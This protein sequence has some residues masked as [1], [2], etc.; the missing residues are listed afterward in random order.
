MNKVIRLNSFYEA[1]S[2]EIDVFD[3]YRIKDKNPVAKFTNGPVKIGIETKEPPIGISSEY[4]TKPMIGIT[5][6][7]NSGWRGKIKEI[8]EL[9]LYIPDSMELDTDSCD[10]SGT[11]EISDKSEY[12]GYSA[13]KLQN[14]V[15]KRKEL[16]DI[17]EP[18]SFKCRLDIRTD[19][20]SDVLGDAPFA[21]KY[22]R[23]SA[24]YIFETEKSA[25]VTVAL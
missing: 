15:K 10:P 16:M 12:E 7:I 4:D 1:V 19:K 24:D 2:E 22:F 3:F 20:L 5:L 14:W 9:I 21:T 6:D 11:F 25:S 13:Y 18:K 23:V 8:K 17:E